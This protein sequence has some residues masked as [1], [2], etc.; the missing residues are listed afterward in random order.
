LPL[1]RWFPS[2]RIDPKGY[3]IL[4]PINASST[5]L[6][7]RAEREHDQRP[8]VLKIL[9]RNAAMPGALARYRHEFEVL[10]SLRIPGVI[11]VLGLETVHGAPMLVLEGFGGQSLASLQR[12]QRF[13]VEQVLVLGSRIAEILG[14]IHDHDVI[15]RDLNP[16]NIL[17]DPDTGT[18]KIADFGWST[19]LAAEAVVDHQ[20][21]AQGSGTTLEYMSPEQTGRMNRP[22]DYRTD[23]YSLG[24]TLYE[25]VTGQ[26]PFVSDNALELVHSHL[27]RQPVPPH[28]LDLGIPAAV[29]DIVMKLMAKMPEDRYQSARGCAHDLDECRQ[30]LATRGTIERFALGQDDFPERFH[31][32]HRLYGRA[33]ELAT[34]LRAFARMVEGS[35]Q[36]LLVTG[37]PGIGKSALIR[38]LGTSTAGGRAYFVEGKYDQ[39]RRNVPYLALAQA[40]SV[41]VRQLL[42]EPEDRLERW[43]QALRHA[44]GPSAG[45]LVEVIPELVSVPECL[46]S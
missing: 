3:R 17:L 35:R 36:L 21:L 16:S 4:E 30:T 13:G 8:V 39:Y 11:Q 22:V 44:L 33:Q 41:L 9:K 20:A 19:R 14:Q 10:D 31:I 1:R 23:F 18:L 42:T 32:A 12:E 29:S 25:L 5:T 40:F 7:Y 24:V 38:E 46:T 43:R 6:V 34:M 37:H 28:E 26:L 15:H 27:A 2:L 45:V